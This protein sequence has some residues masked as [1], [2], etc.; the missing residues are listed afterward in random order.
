MAAV[1]PDWIGHGDSAKPSKSK[2]DYS[3]AAFKTA[4]G[5]FVEAVNI[6]KPL[7]LVVQVRAGMLIRT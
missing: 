4:L 5:K 3:E 7:A 2:F 1:A 6:Q